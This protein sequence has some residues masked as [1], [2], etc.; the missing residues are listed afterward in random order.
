CSGITCFQPATLSVV[1]KY[2]ALYLVCISV[3]MPPPCIK[4]RFSLGT[5]TIAKLTF[6]PRS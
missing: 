1:L 3:D 5:I 4:M 6:G 2:A